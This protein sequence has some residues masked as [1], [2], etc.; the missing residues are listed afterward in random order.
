MCACVCA[1]SLIARLIRIRCRRRNASDAIGTAR[2]ALQ[3]RSREAQEFGNN[4]AQ[5]GIGIAIARRR[6]AEGGNCGQHAGGQIVGN[7]TDRA[8]LWRYHSRDQSLE[9]L[10]GHRRFDIPLLVLLD[11]RTIQLLDHACLCV[12]KV[13]DLL[14]VQR[15]RVIAS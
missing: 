13:I 15:L 9:I 12:Q 2:R 8:N 5:T 10:D 3:Y 11:I 1:I 7:V 4:I 6:T 14:Q